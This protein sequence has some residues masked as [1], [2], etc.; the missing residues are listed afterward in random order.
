M[1]KNEDCMKNKLLSNVD[2]TNKVQNKRGRPRKIIQ[3]AKL[4]E[5][6]KMRGRPRKCINK[7]PEIN[8]KRKFT[9][10]LGETDSDQIGRA[11]V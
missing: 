4:Q 10:S 5:Q 3:E 6:I 11:H 7:S 9:E 2:V 8:K 1:D